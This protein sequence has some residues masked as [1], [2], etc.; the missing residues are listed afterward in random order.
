MSM[1]LIL[2][3]VSLAGSVIGFTVGAVKIGI[4]VGKIKAKAA[5]TDEKYEALKET[6]ETALETARNQ[7]ETLFERSEQNSTNIAKM[8]GRLK[9]DA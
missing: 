6:M 8:Q 7:R 4:E 5:S 2:G 1:E 3:L 9:I